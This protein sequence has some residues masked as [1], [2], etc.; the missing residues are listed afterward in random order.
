MASAQ[1]DACDMYVDD[2]AKLY[3]EGE[4]QKAVDLYTKAIEECDYFGALYGRAVS[5]IYLDEVEKAYN[6]LSTPG[7]AEMYADQFTFSYHLGK[8]QHELFLKEEAY[9]SYKKAESLGMEVKGALAL[10]LGTICYFQQKYEEAEF[11]LT[12]FNAGETGP[13]IANN[14]LGWVYI[15]TKKYDLALE[16]FLSAL[17]YSREHDDIEDQAIMMNNVGYAYGLNGDIKK[18]VKMIEKSIGLDA[19]NSFSY[20]N[21]AFL[22]K[23]KGDKNESCKYLQISLD[24]GIIDKWGEFYVQDII[25]YCSANIP[26]KEELLEV[27]IEDIIDKDGISYWPDENTPFTGMVIV[28]ED[29]IKVG[30]MELKSGINNGL[31][32]VW[33]P[34]GTVETQGQ[35]IGGNRTGEWT[36]WYSNGEKI[37]QVTFV[38]DKEEGRATWWFDN[39]TIEKTGNYKDGVATGVWEWYYA[40]GQLQQR[41]ETLGEIPI[42]NWK[43]YY[44]DGKPMNDGNYVDGM[45]EGP[46]Y[47]WDEEGNKESQVYKKGV[48]ESTGDG[49]DEYINKMEYFI[50]EKDYKNAL[51]SIETA[52]DLV[53]N[54]TESNPEYMNLVTLKANVHS[55]F[56][57]LD[58][59]ERVILSNTGIADDDVELIINS[60]GPGSYADLEMLAQHID[61]S[62][63]AKEN[64]APHIA[65]SLIYNILGDKE[66]LEKEQQLMMDR[67]EHKDWVLSSSMAIYGIR[68]EKEKNTG[69]VHEI[70]DEIKVEGETYMNQMQLAFYHYLLGHID[71]A[72]VI[73]DKFLVERPNEIDCLKLKMNIEMSKGNMEEMNKLKEQILELVPKTGQH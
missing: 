23:L 52:M 42:G 65:L 1:K 7:L 71:Q 16:Q 32:Q 15:E 44:A 43:V 5:Y 8:T 45:L 63:I 21:M 53:E 68:A 70:L 9:H 51:L 13:T 35:I 64:V 18:G 36:S 29:S 67:S 62:E 10:D 72:E 46:F 49:L 22:Y 4:H 47:Y 19:E 28:Y 14:N 17:E 57:Q 58:E 25:E 24:K 26:E 48:I 66:N 54:K 56:N 61:K 6:D 50:N 33:Y 2:A 3:D 20:R 55:T 27:N 39:G 38:N 11:Y 31:L 40:N 30:A 69:I 12:A 34:N 60:I 59:A 73:A 37:R 41:G